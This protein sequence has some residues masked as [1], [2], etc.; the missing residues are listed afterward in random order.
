[1]KKTPK[2]GKSYTKKSQEKC[3]DILINAYGWTE[4]VLIG[5]F[6]ALLYT[7]NDHADA[8]DVK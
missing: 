8:D 1:M 3:L 7:D 2:N 5:F 6:A 4:G